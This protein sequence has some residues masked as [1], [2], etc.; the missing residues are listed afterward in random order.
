LVGVA[1][2]FILVRVAL[3]IFLIFLIILMIFVVDGAE[4]TTIGG[5][6]ATM[7]GA[8]VLSGASISTPTTSK[9][10]EDVSTAA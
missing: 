7:A 9:E 5:R 10:L 8:R 3:L 1:L 6:N 2:H 4:G